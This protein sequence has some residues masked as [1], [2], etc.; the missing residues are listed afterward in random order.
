MVISYLIISAPQSSTGGVIVTCNKLVEATRTSTFVGGSG[1]VVASTTPATLQ[2]IAAHVLPVTSMG[3][4]TS[5]SVTVCDLIPAPDT[6]CVY[7][8]NAM[9]LAES[10]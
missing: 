7:V 4:F 6:V 8:S 2:P 10:A 5:T 9:V 3:R 1:T